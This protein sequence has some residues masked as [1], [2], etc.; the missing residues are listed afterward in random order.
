MAKKNPFWSNLFKKKGEDDHLM[1]T[2]SELPLFSG[3]SHT[4]LKIISGFLSESI[5][6]PDIYNPGD[7]IFEQGQEG[8]GMYV[9]VS[10][11]VNIYLDFHIDDNNLL[12]EL[13]PGDFFG[14][15][16]LLD[17]LPRSATAVVMERS[18][19]L[20]FHG[21]E[22]REVL[23][24]NDEIGYEVIKSLAEVLGKRLRET[25]DLLRKKDLQ[26]RN[27]MEQVRK[28]KAK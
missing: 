9:L 25:D 15:I 14:E 21:R 12:A 26:C 18:E 17:E 10:G 22:F 13:E 11:K 7:F 5:Y 8:A 6:K 20:F 23:R 28:E 16:N 1:E 3:L 2:L 19:V 27:L 24:S 4:K